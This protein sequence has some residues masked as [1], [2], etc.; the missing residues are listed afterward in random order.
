MNFQKIK[1]PTARNLFNGGITVYVLPSKIRLGNDWVKPY[2]LNIFGQDE[3]SF[4]VLLANFEY[5]NCNTETGKNVHYY[6]EAIDSF[7]IIALGGSIMMHCNKGNAGNILSSLQKE[8]NTLASKKI[9]VRSVVQNGSK[10][11]ITAG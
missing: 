7:D 4:D 9:P 3:H 1:K 10:V 8:L 5:Y 2:P 6:I 11:I